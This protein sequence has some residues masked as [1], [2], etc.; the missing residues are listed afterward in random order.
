MGI[1]SQYRL[2]ASGQTRTL[3][4]E[5]S[6]LI[7]EIEMNNGLENGKIIVS[8]DKRFPEVLAYMPSFNKCK[9]CFSETELAFHLNRASVSQNRG[10]VLF[11]P[12]A[13]DFKPTDKQP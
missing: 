11:S 10:S 1:K 9:F 8:G 7:Y 12:P 13:D 4:D 6:P 5:N 2:N 3:S